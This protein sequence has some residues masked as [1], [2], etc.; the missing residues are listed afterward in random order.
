MPLVCHELPQESFRLQLQPILGAS[1]ARISHVLRVVTPLQKGGFAV[2][3][4]HPR[5][6]PREQGPVPAAAALL[7]PPVGPRS[8]S[9]LMPLVYSTPCAASS[10]RAAGSFEAR[11]SCLGPTTTG[12]RRRDA[13][14]KLL[15]SRLHPLVPGRHPLLVGL[16]H[17]PTLKR[18]VRTL[19]LLP[20]VHLP[21]LDRPDRR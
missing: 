9:C 12:D 13:T 17:R 14:R 4:R 18:Q 7:G 3:E 20:N 21:I 16:L 6:A 8:A 2:S 15:P 1:S 19:K 5:A 11:R 10:V